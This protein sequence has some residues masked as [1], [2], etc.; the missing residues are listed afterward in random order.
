MKLNLLFASFIEKKYVDYVKEKFPDLKIIYRTDLIG[1]PR[2]PGDHIGFPTH[3]DSSTQK[4]W[5]NLV[6]MADIIFG[7]DNNLDPNLDLYAKRVKWIQ[8]TSS[9]LG[10]YLSKNRYL[11]KMPNTKFFTRYGGPGMAR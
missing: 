7:F 2:Y 6:G 5:L 1:K 4:E 11:I 8:A 9:G 3:H 10:G